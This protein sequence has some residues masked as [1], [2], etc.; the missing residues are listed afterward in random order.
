MTSIDASVDSGRIGMS[1]SIDDALV[2]NLAAWLD[3]NRPD[4]LPT[5]IPIHVANRDE[6]RG[7]PCV[8]LEAT[9][10]KRVSG[11]PDSARVKLDI[12]L[13][14]QIDDTSAS[15]HADMVAVLHEMLK[16]KASIKQ[17]LNSD[18]FILHDLIIRESSTTRD[19]TRGRESVITYE[20]V[21]SAV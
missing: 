21:V 2:S 12:H 6:L 10:A 17:D 11:L 20:A 3:V 16:A 5:T 19:E 14:T 1:H 13:F 8:V 18:T 15:S 9:D 7:R 4:G